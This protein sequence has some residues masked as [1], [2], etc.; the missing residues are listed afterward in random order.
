LDLWSR[1]REID[2]HTAAKELSQHLLDLP[3]LKSSNREWQPPGPS[4]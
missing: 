4:I 1:Y 3:H 2:L